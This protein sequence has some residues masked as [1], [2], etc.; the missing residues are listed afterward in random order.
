MLT[1]DVGNGMI[2]SVEVLVRGAA[3]TSRSRKG[4]VKTVENTLMTRVRRWKSRPCT[5]KRKAKAGR[6]ERKECI[7]CRELIRGSRLF[8]NLYT[9]RK[10]N[11]CSGM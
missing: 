9:F 10:L 8:R 6:G 3:D 4:I 2:V 7:E 1:V 5:G 11:A